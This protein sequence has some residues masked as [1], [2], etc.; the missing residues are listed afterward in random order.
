MFDFSF[1]QLPLSP[2]QVSFDYRGHKRLTSCCYSGKLPFDDS[3]DVEFF[4]RQE[5]AALDVDM[6]EKEAFFARWVMR[7][8]RLYGISFQQLLKTQNFSKQFGKYLAIG[9]K[10]EA[11]LCSLRP[12]FRWCLIGPM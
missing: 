9:N 11:F 12:A 8:R 2:L 5:M 4:I 10:A 6:F 3:S 1:S 7:H